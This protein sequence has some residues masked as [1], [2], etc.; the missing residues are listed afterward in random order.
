M[1]KLMMMM[2]MGGERKIHA[3]LSE[4]ITISYN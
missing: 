2:M 4:N 1:F 3:A